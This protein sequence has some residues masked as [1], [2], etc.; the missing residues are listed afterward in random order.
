MEWLEYLCRNVEAAYEDLRAEDWGGLELGTHETTP[1]GFDEVAGYLSE[2]GCISERTA[3]EWERLQYELHDAAKEEDKERAWR[4]FD[5]TMELF[6]KTISE[7]NRN[8][9]IPPW[10]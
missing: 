2:E 8:L 7:I 4:L 10:P 6:E 5:Q 1:Y 9:G 3:D